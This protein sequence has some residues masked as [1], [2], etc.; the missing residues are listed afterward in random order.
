M[1]QPPL[2]QQTSKAWKIITFFC[3]TNILDTVSLYKD[4]LN[5]KSGPLYPS[6]H[7]DASVEL[8]STPH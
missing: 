8:R 3:S 6:E 1:M 5:M 2:Q 7:L 4:T